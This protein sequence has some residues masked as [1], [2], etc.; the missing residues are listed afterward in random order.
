MI[1]INHNKINNIDKTNNLN[2][3]GNLNKT[4]DMDKKLLDVYYYIDYD[5][6]INDISLIE[7][8]IQLNIQIN[9]NEYCLNKFI[10]CNVDNNLN[11]NHEGDII[12]KGLLTF[13]KMFR[14]LKLK[15]NVDVWFLYL[16]NGNVKE[17][18]NVFVGLLNKNPCIKTTSY[19]INKSSLQIFKQNT[20]TD[21][22]TTIKLLNNSIRE[23][24]TNNS[25]DRKITYTNLL[26]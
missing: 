24:I 26:D 10:N 20:K 22:L 21:K 8:C 2:K 9:T 13:N 5:D 4:R 7:K 17:Y 1:S 12:K 16:S 14:K 23:L 25:N 18:Q 19:I 15:G 11:K 3:I 6:T